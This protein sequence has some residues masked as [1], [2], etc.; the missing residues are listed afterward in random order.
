MEDRLSIAWSAL[1]RQ[2]EMRSFEL[3]E[4]VRTYPTP[5]ARCDI[6]LTGLLEQRDRAFGRLRLAQDLQRQQS[7]QTRAAWQARLRDFVRSLEATDDAA[8][9]AACEFLID[10]LEQ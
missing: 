1:C 4:E 8:L 5:I 7:S 6:Q 10:T 2:L 9:A 3:L